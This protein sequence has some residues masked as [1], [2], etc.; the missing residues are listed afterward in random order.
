MSL[1]SNSLT[2]GSIRSVQGDIRPGSI[3]CNCYKV[4]FAFPP[5]SDEWRYEARVKVLI[6][7]KHTS[8]RQAIIIAFRTFREI[9]SATE[10]V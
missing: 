2:T 4:F 10:F 9:Y 1:S 7:L 8:D 6:Q 3:P 5:P